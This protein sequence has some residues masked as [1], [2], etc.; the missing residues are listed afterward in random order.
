RRSSSAN[1]AFAAGSPSPR[2]RPRPRPGTAPRGGCSALVPGMAEPCAPRCTPSPAQNEPAPDVRGF[3]A[4]GPS[5]L[6]S[7]VRFRPCLE[8]LMHLRSVLAVLCLC[9]LPL[10]AQAGNGGNANL[11]VTPLAIGSNVTVTITGGPNEWFGLW[12]SY[13]PAVIPTPFGTCWI[14]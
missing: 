4:R 12:Y 10:F 5:G 11:D 13:A 7:I 14:D 8:P 1:A 6:H 9:A 2:G 3:P